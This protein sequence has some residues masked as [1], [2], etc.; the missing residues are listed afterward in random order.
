MPKPVAVVV[1]PTAICFAL[2]RLT[3]GAHTMGCLKKTTRAALLA[4]LPLVVTGGLTTAASTARPREAASRGCPGFTIRRNDGS[5]TTTTYRFGRVKAVRV[6]CQT[7]KHILRDDL[8]GSGRP[9]GPG[10]NWGVNVDGW[11]VTLTAAADGYRGR[12]EFHATVSV[13]AV[14]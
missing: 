3:E 7:V 10:A 2:A 8:R 11:T 13:V 12:A 6:Q 4:A 1:R 5:G 14:G 9:L